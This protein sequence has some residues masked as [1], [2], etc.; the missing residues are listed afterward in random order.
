MPLS[1]PGRRLAPASSV[2][3]IDD[4]DASTRYLTASPPEG[5]EQRYPDDPES[6]QCEERR[7]LVWSSREHRCY[8]ADRKNPAARAVDQRNAVEQDSRVW[9]LGGADQLTG[10]SDLNKPA[11]VHHREPAAQIRH[12]V[13]IMRDEEICHS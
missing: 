3:R 11:E 13:H 7:Q 12:R 2:S 8:F 5:C 6:C 10:G 4:R 1:S 9:M